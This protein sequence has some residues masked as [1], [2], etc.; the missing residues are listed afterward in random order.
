[1]SSKADTQAVEPADVADAVDVADAAVAAR[2]EFKNRVVGLEYRKAKELAVHPKNWRLHPQE[3]RS[4]LTAALESI[5]VAGAVIA[6]RSE[7]RSGQLT[8]IDG[9]LRRDL[10]DEEIPTL[11]LDL[12]D[13]EAEALLATYDVITT[14][15]QRDE[16]A[17]RSLLDGLDGK[18]PRELLVAIDPGL[19]QRLKEMAGEVVETKRP[20]FEIVPQFDEGYDCVI[21]FA[22]REAEWSWLQDQ[23]A[24]PVVKDRKRIGVS[25]V[26]TVDQFKERWSNREQVEHAETEADPPIAAE[27]EDPAEA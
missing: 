1:M 21:V 4:A 18:L 25:H 24:L 3:Q 12:D 16:D 15:A 8:L 26:L 11:V 17:L 6:Y 5:G 9:H 22:S 27:A 19:E 23:L 14:M 7:A 2:P 10:L 13:E 20:P